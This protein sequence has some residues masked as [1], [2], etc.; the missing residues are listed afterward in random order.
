[1]TRDEEIK[2]MRERL[3]QRREQRLFDRDADEAIALVQNRHNAP[4]PQAAKPEP[5]VRK[6]VETATVQE[7]SFP[8]YGGAFSAAACLTIL[9]R[10]F[11][12]EAHYLVILAFA[13]FIMCLSFGYP[14]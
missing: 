1:M 12:T 4:K 11:V 9:A 10:T 13:F 14:L 3:A 2:A 8:T 6:P 5:V 7:V